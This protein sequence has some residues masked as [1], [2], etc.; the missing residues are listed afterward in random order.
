MLYLDI[1]YHVFL[2]LTILGSLFIF[3]GSRIESELVNDKLVKLLHDRFQYIALNN[4]VRN[5]LI[6]TGV[7]SQCF[8][9]RN[10]SLFLGFATIYVVVLIITILLTVYAF[11]TLPREIVVTIIVKNLVVFLFVAVFEALFFFFIVMEY[12]PV[13]QSELNQ[14]I[15]KAVGKA[16]DV[17]PAWN[18]K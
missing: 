5:K 4:D 12:I 10:M 1:I 9:Q 18:A 7:P 2:I 16:L 15:H 13:S 3:W 11:K 6:E 8:K 17:A 14:I